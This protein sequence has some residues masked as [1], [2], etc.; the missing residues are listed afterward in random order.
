EPPFSRARALAD[1]DVA[2]LAQ[3]MKP[4]PPARSYDVAA[5][6]L[7]GM[8]ED[9]HARKIATSLAVWPLVALDPP[10]AHGWQWLLGTP[11]DGLATEHVSVMMYTSILEG[12][13]H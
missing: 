13:S 4:R 1:A 11:V 10:N 6:V 3:G 8:I 7:A 2:R 12:W 9:V 5:A